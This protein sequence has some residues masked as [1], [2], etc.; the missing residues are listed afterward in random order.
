MLF[1]PF[2]LL[3]TIIHLPHSNR[4]TRIVLGAC[5]ILTLPLIILHLK[6][7][8][9]GYSEETKNPPLVLGLQLKHY[10]LVSLHLLESSY[11]RIQRKSVNTSKCRQRLLCLF[12]FIYGR[13]LDSNNIS[14]M[15]YNAHKIA[16]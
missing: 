7:D 5:L 16:H 6:L 8:K 10:L 3:Y 15:L 4:R 14:E 13:H 9:I 1:D 2:N 12:S 11:S